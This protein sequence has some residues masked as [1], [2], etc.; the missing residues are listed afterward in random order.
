MRMATPAPTMTSSTWISG[1]VREMNE[2]PITHLAMLVTPKSMQKVSINSSALCRT[3]WPNVTGRE[4]LDGSTESSI[5]KGVQG[6]Q[7]V[8]EFGEAGVFPHEI[9]SG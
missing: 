7:G 1:N 3:S 2:G 8:Q 9:C 5:T 6:V 4:S